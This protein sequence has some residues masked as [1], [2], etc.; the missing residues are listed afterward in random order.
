MGRKKFLAKISLTDMAKTLNIKR[1]PAK[2]AE[3][4]FFRLKNLRRENLSDNPECVNPVVQFFSDGVLLEPE[5]AIVYPRSFPAQTIRTMVQSGYRDFPDVFVRSVL[6]PPTI[7]HK[8]Y[9]RIE[10]KEV[11]EVEPD[12][13]TFSD[14]SSDSECELPA[15]PA[16]SG[17]RIKQESSMSAA[18]SD[19][20]RKPPRRLKRILPQ[21]S[22]V[23]KKSRYQKLLPSKPVKQEHQPIQSMKIVTQIPTANI[24]ISYSSPA[25]SCHK[26]VLL[27]STLPGSSTPLAHLPGLRS[28]LCVDGN[29]T[30]VSLSEGET[31]NSVKSTTSKI[32]EN[33]GDSLQQND[34]FKGTAGPNSPQK[35]ST[36]VKPIFS[37]PER[38]N[39]MPCLISPPT[40]S[41]QLKKSPLKS[42]LKS[43]TNTYHRSPL[44]AAS[45][46]IIR[47]YTSPLKRRRYSRSSRGGPTTGGGCSSSGSASAAA[48]NSLALTPKRLLLMMSET[49]E[50]GKTTLSGD[51]VLAVSPKTPKTPRN[52]S[53]GAGPSCQDSPRGVGGGGGDTEFDTPTGLGRRKSRLQREAEATATMLSDCLESTEEREA[54]EQRESQQ[55]FSAMHAVIA[56]NKDLLQRYEEIM[57]GAEEL[58]VCGTYTQL[59][60]LM[61]DFPDVQELL[62][63]LLSEEEALD[64]GLETYSAFCERARLKKFLC[65]LSIVYK[66]Q[67]AYHAKV[68]KELETLSKDTTLTCERLKE[69]SCQLFRNNQHLMEEFQML[70]PGIPPP[71][72]MLQ[73]PEHL[74]LPEEGHEEGAGAEEQLYVPR[75]PD[76]NIEN[77]RSGNIR[78]SGGR[79]FVMEGKILRPATI[80][81]VALD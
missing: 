33:N 68:L 21:N 7:S 9:K 62:L 65:K 30:P 47:K 37:S 58:G 1:I 32:Q 18:A 15:A 25:V 35:L 80:D 45:D 77:T 8:R 55:L 26:A 38:N 34:S 59:H 64:L 14:F 44:K 22:P 11:I 27:S 29:E 4:I 2:S 53:D 13:S 73:S 74:T 57:G 49:E 28:A 6:Q 42:P 69:I 67:P 79:C 46:R 20:R 78:F 61:S 23:R 56:D 72:S 3:Q 40:S 17:L 48:A 39:S 71:Q 19:V 63:D 81:K 5:D 10:P 12:I 31:P 24:A 60:D 36:A 76:H 54:R 70:I 43:L 66:H 16:N 50:D 52:S 41:L 51:R 75:S